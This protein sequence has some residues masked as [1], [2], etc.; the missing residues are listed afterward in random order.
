MALDVSSSILKQPDWQGL[1]HLADTQS[2]NRL[3]QQE[4][5]QQMQGKRNAAGAFLN[6]Y[7]DKKDYLT[8]TAADGILVKMLQ[9]ATQQGAQMAQQ[10][11]D[12]PTLL[13]A[14]TPLVSKINDYSTRAKA[15]N[16]QADDM[17][18]KMKQNGYTGYD[19][20]TLKDEAL[21]S[22][23]FNA[24]P[25]TGQPTL[26]PSKAD[27]STNWVL[28]AIDET[29]EKVTT[30]AGLDL[31]AKNSPMQKTTSDITTY[32][33]GGGYSRGKSH[34]IG[35]NW[36]TPD[37]DEKGVTTG[38]VPKHDIATENG[39]PLIHDFNG[40][41]A[42]VRLLDEG[43]FDDM[44]QKRPDV[45]DYMKGLVKQHLAEY[46]NP[47]GSPVA[48]QDPRAK[49]VARAIAYDELNRRKASTIE[50]AAVENKPSPMQVRLQ[51]GDSPQYL[52]MLQDQAQARTEGHQAGK[53]GGTGNPVE[54]IGHIFNN[55][56]DY[57]GGDVEKVDGRNVVNVTGAFPAGGL[58]SG[59]GDAFKYRQIYFDPEK[60]ALV[61]EKETTT[62]DPI[63]GKE[64]KVAY[65]T[66]PE[67]KVGQFMNTIG[68]G[69]GVSPERVR[70]IQQQFGYK[71]GKFA[72]ST[73]PAREVQQD[74]PAP[75]ALESFDKSGKV[76]D[77]KPLEGQQVKDGVVKKIDKTSSLNLM[78]DYYITVQKPDGK[79]E[80]IK[81]KNKAAL[82]EYLNGG[83][84][85]VPPST[86]TP[87]APKTKK[88][89]KYGI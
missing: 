17:I 66:Y 12:T 59:K 10:G 43:T 84:S 48:M 74:A 11:A 16:K 29:P 60:R 77:L 49:M 75:G 1:Y 86:P 30:S 58:K 72:G 80:D 88:Q 71:D 15:I 2:R 85:Q 56:P 5:D 44:M 89:N 61:V 34:L 7:L 40:T 79:E 55:N 52:K 68:G 26:D 35:Q 81:F 21:K 41:K 54:T 9:E 3:R 25:K 33:P 31:F 83:G 39:Q 24:D 6:N 45:A 67:N 51:L 82:K 64:V 28:K 70:Q 57:T 42:P 38:L 73:A 50:Q 20:G 32:N 63:R 78:N 69:N 46:K 13:T 14:L 23:F 65:E 37:V 47:D 22:A 18:T 4:L 53:G 87:A 36:L 27:P 19:F 62:N 8:G 76:A